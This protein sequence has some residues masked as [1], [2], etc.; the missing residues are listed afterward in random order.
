[1][2]AAGLIG[3]G[4]GPRGAVLEHTEGGRSREPSSRPEQPCHVYMLD[5]AAKF[6]RSQRYPCPP[7][8]DANCGFK[9]SA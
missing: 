3:H 9:D 5:G 7:I 2:V 1:M 4:C 6:G 8:L